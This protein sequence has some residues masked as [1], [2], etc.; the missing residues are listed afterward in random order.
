MSGK[1]YKM[2]LNIIIIFLGYLASALLYVK[3]NKFFIFTEFI[4]S[5]FIALLGHPITVV[6]VIFSYLGKGKYKL[7]WFGRLLLSILIIVWC[8]LAFFLI[9]DSLFAH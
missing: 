4:H 1:F 2:L 7:D 8:V 5:D 3:V 9:K 6:V